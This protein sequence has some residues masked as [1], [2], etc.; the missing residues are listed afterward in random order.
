MKILIISLLVFSLSA[1]SQSLNI[2]DVV[3]V[4][5]TNNPIARN[6]A[7]KD[8]WQQ[9]IVLY[10]LQWQV[11]AAYFDVIYHYNR[12]N[13]IYMHDNYFEAFMS[14]VEIYIDADSISELTKFSTGAFFASHQ[15]HRYVAAEELKRAER[16]LRQIMYIEMPSIELSSTD[17]D[18]YQIHPNRLAIDRFNALEHK[19]FDDNQLLKAQSAIKN[20]K[21]RWL[22]P[23]R[24]AR[25]SKAQAHA[26][27][28]AYEIE[29]RKFYNLQR[30]EILKSLLNEYYVQITL[31]NEVLLIEAALA[32]KD[33][34]TR[35]I[36]GHISNY[37]EAF[38]VATDAVNA[39]LNRLEYIR[40]Y[41]LTALE[42]EYYTR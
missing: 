41:N 28:T 26:D 3:N 36:D 20:E 9:A 1:K 30:I 6:I 31:S 15:S 34:E 11:K 32:L 14:M 37:A 33:L 10:E 17:F 21:K 12:L 25:I 24:R 16:R 27:A 39:K 29:Y 19:Y 23:K 8:S 5:L 40:L 2:D 35:F 7:L 18:L 22:Y 38:K 13:T 42:L 4:A